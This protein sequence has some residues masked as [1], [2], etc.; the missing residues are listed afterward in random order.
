MTYSDRG[1]ARSRYPPLGIQGSAG[2]KVGSLPLRIQG[3]QRTGLVPGRSLPV[4]LDFPSA[5]TAQSIHL[6]NVYWLPTTRQGLL[7]IWNTS[8]DA[9]SKVPAF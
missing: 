8:V 1:G 3:E 7:G 5:F 6:T 4:A 2:D 9:E